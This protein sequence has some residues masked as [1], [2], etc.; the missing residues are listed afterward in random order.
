MPFG[1]TEAL[2]LLAFG[3][4]VRLREHH[5]HRMRRRQCQ[6]L[7]VAL[8]KC[9][10]H[11]HNQDHSRK[12]LPLGEVCRDLLPPASLHRFRYLRIAVAR[13]IDHTS[14]GIEGKH[15]EGLRAARLFTHLREPTLGK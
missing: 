15:V 12:A 14:C 7:I 8:P 11:I 4:F 9:M 10:A 13:Q 2:V 5:H 3:Q 1:L 6:K